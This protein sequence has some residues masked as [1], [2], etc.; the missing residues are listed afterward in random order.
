MQRRQWDNDDDIEDEDDE[1]ADE[2]RWDVEM[3]VGSVGD[4][5]LDYYESLVLC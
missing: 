1:E 5:E 3:A 4:Q 2:V